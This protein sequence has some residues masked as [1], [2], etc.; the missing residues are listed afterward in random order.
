M[1]FCIFF[2]YSCQQ[3]CIN[4]EGSSSCSCHDGY[5]LN[6][7]GFSCTDIDECVENNGNCSNIC[8]NLIGSHSCACEAGFM[9]GS[10]NETCYDVDEC[11]EINDCSHICINTEGT[12]ECDCPKGFILGHDQFNCHDIDECLHS[13]CIAG[14]CRNTNGSFECHCS[15]GFEL[16]DDGVSCIDIDECNH[17][18]HRHSCSHHCTNSIGG[19]VDAKH[20]LNSHLLTNYSS[21]SFNCSCPEGMHLSDDSKTCQDVDEC[22]TDS[23]CSHVCENIERGFVWT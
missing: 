18:L 20:R 3:T 2:W 22:E 9:L 6:K 12:Y 14:E 4:T 11:L 1:L 16:S 23:P 8:I 10:D 19:W 7:N 21:C 17:H 13:P 15:S 5:E